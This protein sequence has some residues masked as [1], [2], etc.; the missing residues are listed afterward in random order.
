MRIHPYREHSRIKLIEARILRK[1][2]HEGEH[3]RV[4]DFKIRVWWKG[5]SLVQGAIVKKTFHRTIWIRGIPFKNKDNV[6]LVVSPCPPMLSA[7]IGILCP[8]D[9]KVYWC[10]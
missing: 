5:T 9:D 2:A 7:P 10:S 1:F 3:G 4:S 6:K 8:E